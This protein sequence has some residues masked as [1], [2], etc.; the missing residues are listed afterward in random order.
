[1]SRITGM[2]K[3]AYTFISFIFL[4][5]ISCQNRED[6]MCYVIMYMYIIRYVII[7][8]II[9]MTCDMLCH[10]LITMN[11]LFDSNIYLFDSRQYLFRKYH[12]GTEYVD[13]P[14]FVHH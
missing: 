8:V 5:L 13:I 3:F 10:I 14:V 6:G 9:Y 12:I 11:D 2:A 7:Y 1:M 4:L